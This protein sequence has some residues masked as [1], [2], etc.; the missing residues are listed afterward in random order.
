MKG[1]TVNADWGEETWKDVPGYGGF[2]EASSLGRIRAKER[3]VE[4]ATRHGGMMIQRYQARILNPSVEKGYLRVHLGFDGK[5]IKAW[6]HS[7][8]LRAFVG[9]PAEDQ[10]TRHLNGVRTDNRPENLAWGTHLENMADRKAHGK[11]A[12]ADRHVM[13]KLTREDVRLIR[14]SKQSGADLARLLCVSQSQISSIRKGKS[15]R[16]SV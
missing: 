1:R 8:V 5:K 7:L 13:A 16:Q 9:E 12:E 11:Y 14:E 15:W 2:Y 6:V 10:I 3:L 4:K